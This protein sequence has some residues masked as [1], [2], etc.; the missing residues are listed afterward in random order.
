MISQVAILA[1]GL[2]TRLGSLTEKLPKPL[3]EVAGRPFLEWQLEDV[4][5]QGFKRV[6]LL[7]AY[8]G[9]KIE[10]Y[11]GSGSKFGLEI[12]YA[13]EPEPLGTGGALR[14]ARPKLDDSFFMLNGDSFLPVALKEMGTAFEKSNSKVLISLYDNNPP[15][16]VPE[17][18]KLKDGG[19]TVVAY[20]KAAGRAAGFTH[21]DSGAYVIS[22][23]L[24]D[25]IPE[26]KS[27]LEELWPQLILEKGLSGF[28]VES[29]F[30]DIGT[31]E[32]IKEFEDFVRTRKA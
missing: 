18:I 14:L 10:D 3:I 6:L 2:G 29:R 28:E 26:G 7:V 23:S 11:F 24:L 19:T 4:R 5:N 31:P 22:K 13:Y 21:I 17:N 30:Y 15:C 16:P 9:K 32:R 1:G 25:R 12:E 20:K 8:L 27:Q